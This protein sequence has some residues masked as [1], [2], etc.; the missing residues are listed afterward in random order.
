MFQVSATSKVLKD[1]ISIWIWGSFLG[2]LLV[3]TPLQIGCLTFLQCLP[4]V[5]RSRQPP[6][7]RP[8][9]VDIFV[10]RYPFALIHYITLLFVALLFFFIFF[11]FFI[12]FLCTVRGVVDVIWCNQPALCV[13]VFLIL[14]LW[15]TYEF[16]KLIRK[17]ITKLCKQAHLCL[18]QI[19]FNVYALSEKQIYRL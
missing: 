1:I 17:T 2:P 5:L 12:C 16:W 18:L 14:M 7:L 4:S 8:L 13:A 9:L 6:S 11:I 3:H 10:L 19:Y 15:I